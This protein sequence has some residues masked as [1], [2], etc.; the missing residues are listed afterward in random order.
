MPILKR[1]K[2]LYWTAHAKGKMRQYGLS[3]ARVRRVIHS[4]RRVEEGIAP[5][6]IA[7]MQPAT[8]TG[9]KRGSR[10]ETWKQE[11]WVMIV[12]EKLRRKIISSWRYPGVTKQGD[13]LP[14][15]ILRDLY[16][17]SML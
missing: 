5:D 17:S 15:E 13:A 14:P 10:G 9:M 16:A 11:I 2:V 1:P 8:V 6:T 7:V 12:E 4:P 3:E